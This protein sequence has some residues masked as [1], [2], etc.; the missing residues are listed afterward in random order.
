[1][2][3]AALGQERPEWDD[4]KVIQTGVEK[5]HATMM[6]Y[7][8]AAL[9][10]AGDPARS[11]WLLSLNGE[12]KFHCSPNP[13]AR[14]A[15]FYRT[16]YND[17]AWQSIPVPSSYELHGCDIPIYT[18]IIYP[19]PMDPQ[20]PPVVPHEVN[21]V[22][23][24]RR[25]FTAPAGWAGRQVFL[26][27][28]GVDSAFYVWVNGTK[29]GYSEDSRTPAEFN[30]TRLLKPGQNTLAVEVYRFSDGAYLEDQD[31]WRLS[32]IYRDVFLW[33]TAPLHIRDFEVHTGLDADY[34]DAVLRAG[35][36]VANYG[37]AATSSSV[38]LELLDAAGKPVFAPQ[39]KDAQAAARGEGEA[40]FSVPVP[41]PRK[42]TAETPELYRLL[43][44]LKDRSGKTLEVIPWN[45][46]FRKVEIRGGRFLVNGKP[47]L[48]KGVNR[49]E[50][51]PDTAKYVPH[52]L[53]VKDVELM[54][55]FNVNAVRTSHYP[56]HT[57]WYDLCDRYG[58]YVMDE[59]N[60]ECHGYG[61][62]PQNRLSNDPEWS[63]MYLNRVRRMVERDKNHASVI[64][65]SMGNE[66]G[67]G[68]NPA[69]CYRWTKERDP[70][71]PFHYEGTTSHGGSNADINSFMYPPPRE[72]V[73][74][75]AKRPDMPLILC[76][77]SHSMGNTDG[78]LKEYWDIFY[79][80]TNAQGAFVWDWVDQGIRQPV[81][82]DKEAASGLKTFLAYGG[83]WEDPRGIRNDNNF[84]MNGLV[85]ADRN[86][87]PGL[88]A[89]KY[90]YRNIHA[91]PV[92][93]AEG[94]IKVRNW[95]F[96]LNTKDVTEGRWEVKAGERTVAAGKLPELDIP[97][98]A[99]KEYTLPLPR[100]Y[101]VPP[102]A[103]PFLNLSFVTKGDCAWAKAGH[104]LAWEQFALGAPAP[105]ARAAGALAKLDLT[106]QGGEVRLGNGG[107]SLVFDKAAGT[108]SSYT[109]RGT[110]LIERGPVPDFWR[111][112]TDNDR[113]AL[114][115]LEAISNPKGEIPKSGPLKSILVWRGVG[116]S[117]KVT[118]V[119]VKRVNE[120]TA[121]I[122]VQAELPAVAARYAMKYTVYG[123]GDVVVE[124]SYE[125]GKIK[126]MMP[127]FGTELVLSPGLENMK[128][129]GR[130]PVETHQ[131][132]K[133]ER[134]GVYSSTVDRE[135]VDYS[136]P[137]ENGN[138][139]EVR[140]VALTNDRG[141]GLAAVGAPLLSV[142]AKHFMK[143]DMEESEYT[144]QIP[145]HKEI[146]LNLDGLQMGAGGIDSW[147][148][149]AFPMAPYRIAPDQPHSFKYRLS[150]VAGDVNEALKQRF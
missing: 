40:N 73:R 104:E 44:T 63:D 2:S 148:L 126:T 33:S 117:W 8:T 105:A 97:P 135:W 75:A 66:S 5:P 101:D 124:A 23:S 38:T 129:H 49:H 121:A 50:H 96:F 72:V 65:W 149:N 41:N 12:W 9:A 6:V 71:R 119:D 130:G 27:F 34:R 139:V 47:V 42:W 26:H 143:R 127:R 68:P 14:P 67:D 93:L 52:E 57:D 62:D 46:G 133:F 145:R 74:Q 60:I 21:S 136:R 110:R 79:S 141:V 61:N 10:R 76:E 88:Y 83:W 115:S 94:R 102:L 51:S 146:F 36:S 77:Y 20:K 25:T 37:G 90:V 64:A 22:G 56:N 147:S 29:V 1:V 24:Y 59:A 28:A 69:L 140:W 54:K 82:A 112:M 107:F 134:I 81:P 45:V 13:A 144:F 103:Q 53:M 78:G 106:E 113:G 30:I 128:W 48:I 70:S 91:K 17:A 18:N 95:F 39:V 122:T 31:M 99:E 123:S 108:I 100:Q 32:G 125:P 16:D 98:G 15:D 85:D 118:G 131:D 43:L 86:P 114:K 4:V 150:P 80:G 55:R 109:Y 3:A 58:L 132:R 137:Q 84:Q 7:P 138:K 89:I 92:E 111:A 120:S 87:H 142:G 11:P 35:A 19:F 116:P